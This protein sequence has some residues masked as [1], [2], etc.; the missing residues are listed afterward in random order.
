MDN[1]LNI[2]L[3]EEDFNLILEK[4]YLTELERSVLNNDLEKIKLLIS[5]GETIYSTTK[6]CNGYLDRKYKNPH[7]K[8]LKNIC[9]KTALYYAFIINYYIL[10]HIYHYFKKYKENFSESNK[11]IN[12]LEECSCGCECSYTFNLYYTSSSFIFFNL[13]KKIPEIIS[14]ILNQDQ[15][16]K[17]DNKFQSFNFNI[18]NME[19]LHNKTSAND[20]ELSL[21]SMYEKY[22]INNKIINILL[23]QQ[24]FEIYKFY[25]LNNLDI[26]HQ[27]DNIYKDSETNINYVNPHDNKTI[28]T[29]TLLFIDNDKLINMLLEKGANIPENINSI[30]KDC[31]DLGFYKSVKILIRKIKVEHLYL[32]F[33]LFREILQNNKIHEE[34][35]LEMMKIIEERQ[36][37]NLTNKLLVDILKSQISLKCFNIIINNN[38]FCDTIDQS[39]ISYCIQIKKFMELD[40]LL[41][42][43]R[44]SLINGEDL[45]QIPLFIYL[46]ETFSDD[47]ENLN[48]L[49]TLLRFN[50][51]LDILN[52]LNESPLIIATKN[53][54]KDSVLLL[55]NRGAN[56]FLRDN[57]FDNC[58][59]IAIKNNYHELVEILCKYKS[60]GV[61]LVNEPTNDMFS[62]LTLCLNSKEPIKYFKY[63]INTEGINLNYI[64]S[65]NK[66]ILF[67]I[68]AHKELTDEIKN[69]LTILLLEKNINLREICNNDKNILLMCI[70]K[71]LFQI[72]KLIINKL[73]ECKEII[74]DDD[75]IISAL[76]N[77]K[78]NNHHLK[79]IYSPAISYLRQ[80]MF[81]LKLNNNQLNK[82]DSKITLQDMINIKNN[83]YITILFM[84]IFLVLGLLEKNIKNF[85][86]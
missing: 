79:N 77:N 3:S 66:N 48:I 33:C 53:N 1:H 85:R 78:I 19:C 73:I 56:P 23:N 25:L 21:I 32:P 67:Y 22:E 4:D 13:S 30:I 83:I 81:K 36:N 82:N 27:I 15:S 51:K 59:H 52:A 55:L 11:I 17:P 43:G 35:K 40:L 38:K 69:N 14:H 12:E 68:I 28:L 84:L 65:N 61:Y 75:D 47:S 49:N 44:Q 70:E 63:L 34:E 60:E 41:K 8:C 7:S 64:D 86:K 10:K 37:V 24:S 16:N 72:V 5:R 74:I 20:N 46:K 9:C 39:V 76:K 57:N 80:N 71:D 29:L 26:Y 2:I 50:P 54:R 58:L 31:L 62:C 45:H 6:L 42:N 18:K